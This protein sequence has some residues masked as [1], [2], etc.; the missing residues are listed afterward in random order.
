MTS[1]KYENKKEFFNLKTKLVQKFEF[2]KFLLELQMQQI[3]L[4]R[5][6]DINKIRKIL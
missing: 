2:Q 1:P 4:E 6:F 3:T 5:K